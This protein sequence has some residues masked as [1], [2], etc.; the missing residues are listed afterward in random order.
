M[1]PVVFLGP[2]LARADAEA[3]LPA[4]Y[5][6]PVRQGDVYRAVRDGARLIGIVD[7][8]FHDVPSVWHKE[9]LFALHEGAAVMG[10]ASMGALRAAELHAFGMEGVG[11]VFE[12][13]RDGRLTDDDEVAVQHGPAE[14]GYPALSEALVNIRATLAAAERAGVIDGALRAELESLGKALFYPERSW[15]ALLAGARARA[16]PAEP[17]STLEAWLPANRVNQKRSD[18]LALLEAL[19]HR[20]AQPARPAPRFRFEPTEIWQRFVEQQNRPG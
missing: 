20:T 2:S 13:F 6:P 5:R 19:R 14:L 12:A 15:G 10:A 7:G 1:I 3:V 16:L 4:D 9:I 18:A 11:A 8:C 17:L